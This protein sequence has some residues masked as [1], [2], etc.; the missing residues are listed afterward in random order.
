M[1]SSGSI[2]SLGLGSFSSGL[3]P[4]TS[5]LGGSSPLSLPTIPSMPTIPS[6]LPITSKASDTIVAAPGLPALKRSLVDQIISAKYVDFGELPPAK[7]LGK[8]PPS[9]SGDTEGQIVL[10]Q[11]ADYLQSRRQVKDFATW[12]Q[13]FALY[14]AVL[15]SGHPGRA[16]S[17]FQYSAIVAKL[18]KKFRWIIY[19]Q[20]FRHE[21]AD[22]GNTK[23]DR[24][25]SSI[26]AQCFTGM[27]LC[28]E[29]W[30]SLC[31]SLDHVRTTCPFK[32]PIDY[33]RRTPSEGNRP[34]SEYQRPPPDYSR[35]D[36]AQSRRPSPRPK[37][38]SKRPRPQFPSEEACR[39]WNRY[40]YMDCPHGDTCGYAHVCSNCRETDHGVLKCS[41]PTKASHK[42][43][44]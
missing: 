2:R 10:I 28:E 1:P 41:N 44:K 30:C 14:S 19:D 37:P 23:W 27:S 3:T 39:K 24:V 16:Q 40:N 5:A 38:P 4:P 31:A 9:M 36:Y 35:P 12:S 18:S 21:A 22:S 13:C 26:H 34:P 6:L 7:G 25:D 33:Y 42:A 29:G 11:A 43:A 15:L 32:P 17:L 8:A 20:Q